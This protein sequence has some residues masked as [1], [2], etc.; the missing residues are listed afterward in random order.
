MAV[1]SGLVRIWFRGIVIDAKARGSRIV[2]LVVRA[3]DQD[4]RPLRRFLQYLANALYRAGDMLN[5]GNHNG[6]P[7]VI[8]VMMLEHKLDNGLTDASH[9]YAVNRIPSYLAD[10]EASYET[11]IVYEGVENKKLECLAA[12]GVKAENLFD[13]PEGIRSR[14]YECT[15][16]VHVF[17]PD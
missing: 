10:G 14:L 16:N 8:E 13:M 15:N 1:A 11:L 2:N 17:P 5:P 6:L 7:R 4:S 12:G 9:F 3:N